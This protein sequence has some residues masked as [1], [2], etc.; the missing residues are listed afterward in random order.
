MNETTMYR[1]MILAM[2]LLVPTAALA[3]D[4]DAPADEAP[5]EGE[6]T[7]DAP[8][9]EAPPKGS[10]EAAEAAR[11]AG[12]EGAEEA[13]EATTEAVEDTTEAVEDTTEAVEGTTE[14]VEGTTEGAE[15]ATDAV[16]EAVEAAAEVAKATVEADAPADAPEPKPKV[17]L[18]VEAGALW[19]AGN[20]KSIS[21]NG[22]VHFGVTHHKNKFGLD[23]AGAYGSGAVADS[24]S[25]EWVELAKNVGGALRYDRFLIP[26]LNS[27]YASGGALHDPLAGFLVQARGDLGYSH[28]LLKNDKHSLVAEGGFN[29]SRDQYLPIAEGGPGGGQNFLGGRVAGAYALNVNDVFGFTQSLEAL[30]GGRQNQ[31]AGEEGFDGKI[32]SMTGLSGTLSKVFSVKVGFK[33]GYDFVPPV[34]ADGTSYEALDTA[35]SI[36]LVATIM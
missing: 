5:A 35:A 19:L 30:L 12:E 13:I 23:F 22:A 10:R 4:E 16:D 26:D 3:G 2:L 29:Y 9:D 31:D 36:T 15:A 34:K 14:A 1:T 11:A 17:V 7:E 32:T 8:A 25:D 20:S 27:L 33:L 6:P 21:A 24:G 18:S 28:Q